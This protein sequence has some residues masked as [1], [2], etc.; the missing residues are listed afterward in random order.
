VSERLRLYYAPGSCSLAP[1]V[2][3]EEAG[4]DFEPVRVDFARAEQREPAYLAVNQ[5]GRVP[6]LAQGDWVLTENPAILRHVARLYPSAGLWPEEPRAEA[7]C[8]EWLAWIA[9]TVHPAYAHVRRAERYA[10]S[11]AGKAEV[12]DRGREACADLWS[13]IEVNLVR[14]PYA[15]GDA[16]SVADIYLMVFWLWGRGPVLGYDMPRLF[17]TWTD[18]MRRVGARPGARRALERE[19]IAPP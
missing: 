3:L 13:M 11:E 7:L 1:H 16:F 5:K 2:A 8:L 15:A 12:V 19:G 10:T 4:A 9:S 18:L 6:A 14:H 17:P